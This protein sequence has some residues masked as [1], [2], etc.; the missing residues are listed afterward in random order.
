MDSGSLLNSIRQSLRTAKFTSQPFP[1]RLRFTVY[2]P[3][4]R[5]RQYPVPQSHMTSAQCR[6]ARELLGWAQGDVASAGVSPSSIVNIEDRR[7][8]SERWGAREAI[9]SHQFPVK[10]NK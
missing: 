6:A 4:P 3:S 1:N 10:S 2:S 5:P 9:L 8:V 7:K